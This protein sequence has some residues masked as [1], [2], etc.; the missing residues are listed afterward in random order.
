[1]ERSEI[2]R[3]PLETDMDLICRSW[4]TMIQLIPAESSNIKI[5]RLNK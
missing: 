3:L 1:M 5:A 4:R 2:E